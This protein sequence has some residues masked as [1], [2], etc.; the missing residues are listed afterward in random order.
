M[1]R[2][3]FDRYGRPYPARRAGRLGG[4]VVRTAVFWLAVLTLLVVAANAL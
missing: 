1:P 4:S 3:Y 2:C